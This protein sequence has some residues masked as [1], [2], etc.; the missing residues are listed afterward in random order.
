M[1]ILA[2]YG[3]LIMTRHNRK[4]G[5]T[6]WLIIYNITENNNN[7]D[8]HRLCGAEWTRLPCSYDGC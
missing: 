3:V 8:G 6:H 2:F 1:N 4:P 7:L 5:T